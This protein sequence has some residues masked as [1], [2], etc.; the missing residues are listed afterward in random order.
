MADRIQMRRDTAARWQQ[1]NPILLEGEVG[2]VLD[3]PNQY[4]IGDGVRNWNDLPLRG[5]DGTLVHTLGDSETAAMSQKGVT[6]EFMALSVINPQVLNSYNKI[7]PDRLILGKGIVPNTGG[8]G[9]Y[10]QLFVTNYIDVL[11]VDKVY[12][13]V[14]ANGSMYAYD[15]DFA[16][17]SAVSHSET[18]Y[19]L[20]EN[21][22]YIRL[23]GNQTL[24]DSRSLYLYMEEE[25]TY[26]A[27]GITKD[28]IYTDEQIAGFDDKID[29]LKEDMRIVETSNQYINK[30]NYE[31]DFIDGYI[32]VNGKET[33]SAS[34]CV[35]HFIDVLGLEKVYSNV[36]GNGSIAGYDENKNYV[37]LLSQSP[38]GVY[39]IED[40]IRYIR[41]T[42]KNSNDK[43]LL[44]LYT[45]EK[46]VNLNQV[47]SSTFYDYGITYTDAKYRE[48]LDVIPS[49]LDAFHSMYINSINMFTTDLIQEEGCMLNTTDGVSI[50]KSGATSKQCYSKFIPV[51]GGKIIS[52]NIRAY[53][54][55]LSYDKEKNFLGTLSGWISYARFRNSMAY[56]VLSSEVAF[57]RFNTRNDY[58]NLYCLSIGD[59]IVY[60]NIYKYGETFDSHFKY[61]GKKL[62][63]IGDSITYQRTW[64]D[65]LCELTGLWHN[66]KEV[67]GADESV[68]T[69]GYGYILLTAGNE[70]TDTYYEEVEGITKSDE[71]VVD[72]FGY[73]HPIWTDVDGNKYRQPCRTAEGGETVMPVRPT[74]IYSRASD[75]KYY[76]GDVIIVFAGANDK[77]TY[78]TSYPTA[79]GISAIQGLTNLKTESEDKTEST[80]EI[81]TDNKVLEATGDYSDVGET[82]GVA[83]YNYT[84]RACFRGML[85]RVVDA[86]PDAKI[87]V[88]GPF[89]TMIKGNDYISRGYDYLTTE[90][91]KVIEEC[92]REFS[93]QY[94]DLFPLFGRYRASK[95]FGG[96]D[97]TVYIHPTKDGG[98][99]IAEYIASMIM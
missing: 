38:N 50:V 33:A 1:F 53:G 52:T 92:A 58:Y 71:T 93:C 45:D 54:S 82:T 59:D 29:G 85:K 12:S 94:I 55:V 3:N 62:V 9:D 6:D 34:G 5:F 31:T 89:A 67:R 69:E 15:E 80:F 48:E 14:Y 10:P 7:D 27:Y 30:I 65:R 57:I 37:K 17:I 16:F 83:K 77:V 75:S 63:T 8:I 20:P 46:F 47:F 42:Y 79:G 90:Q 21:T 70:D 19:A 44:F 97:G 4:K 73:A 64:Q 88:I 11:G 41:F 98:R 84:F 49:K 72:G 61:R 25:N 22:R 56:R 91:N 95:F 23:S 2:Y 43:S 39:T 60:D 24:I 66:P 74:S 40:G 18:E 96:S 68:K 86:N 26:H 78:I 81:Y 99:E 36:Y 32:L 35:T 87:I 28:K 13:Q 76:K 51:T